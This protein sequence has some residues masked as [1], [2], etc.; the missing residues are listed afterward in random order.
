[1]SL[2]LFSLSVIC[3]LFAKYDCNLHSTK[4]IPDVHVSVLVN[5]ESYILYLIS[6]PA[7][8]FVPL[9]ASPAGLDW[10]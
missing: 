8:H 4:Q 5:K 3:E 6:S 1:M 2:I 7:S 10:L 9:R